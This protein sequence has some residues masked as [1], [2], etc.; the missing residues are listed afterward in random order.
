[1]WERRETNAVGIRCTCEFV[2]HLSVSHLIYQTVFDI[3]VKGAKKRSKKDGEQ[4]RIEEL[5]CA[6]LYTKPNQKKLLFFPP[7]TLWFTQ[8]N[9]NAACKCKWKKKPLLRNKCAQRLNHMCI[10]AIG[11]QNSIC[12]HPPKNEEEINSTVTCMKLYSLFSI[13]ITFVDWLLLL[14]VLVIVAFAYAI[15][16]FQT[17]NENWKS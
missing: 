9:Y 16:R 12:I 13:T 8:L 2:F 11:E 6:A 1:M 7:H 15:C 10:I 14:F 17:F 3:L 4:K 5:R